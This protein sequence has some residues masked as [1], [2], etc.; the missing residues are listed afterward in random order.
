[1]TNI[2]RCL[3]VVAGAVVVAFL[4]VIATGAAHA[5]TASCTSLS[6]GQSQ[7]ITAFSIC[8]KVTLN[9]VPTPSTGVTG[10][11]VPTNTTAAEWQSFYDN[12]PAGVTIAACSGGCSGYSYGGYCYYY[13]GDGVTQSC[14]TTCASNG[15]CNLA[16]TRFIGSDDPGSTRCSA[17]ATALAGSAI[18]AGG[19]GTGFEGCMMNTLKGGWIGN[20]WYQATTTCAAASYSGRICACNSGGGSAPCNLPWGGTTPHNTSVTAYQS[21]SVPCGNSCVSE[22]RTCSNGT[23]SGSYTNSGCTVGGCSSC[24]TSWGQ[25]I[26]NGQSN[27]LSSPL[28]YQSDI[29]CSDQAGYRC[30]ALRILI[31]CAGGTLTCHTASYGNI[32][33]WDTTFTSCVNED[34][35]GGEPPCCFVKEAQITMADGSHKPI[36]ELKVGDKVK[37]E[38]GI[39]TVLQ[40]VV[41]QKHETLYG[42]NGSKPFVTSGHPFKTQDGWKA[43]EPS[44]TKAEGHAVTTTKL[45]VGDTLYLEDG[46][47]VIITSIDPHPQ[48]DMFQTYSPVVDGD[49]TYYSNGFL[50]HN[51]NIC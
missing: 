12:P 41:R 45:E 2:E 23:L 44:M 33:C 32:S 49:N 5:Q 38:K 42:I 25:T 18:T 24:T 35:F 40:L 28:Q 10:I 11:C 46:S 50:V 17:V 22:T 3:Y 29:G 34:C 43:M 30:N 27:V 39:N 51:K 19:S 6:I 26:N 9:S 21:A 14:D 7:D 48:G 31:D 13:T 4:V 47:T 1:M 16:G 20:N 8:K 15:G 37:G 36:S